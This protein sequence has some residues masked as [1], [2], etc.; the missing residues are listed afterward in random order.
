[1]LSLA[2]HQTIQHVIDN[3]LISTLEYRNESDPD[4]IPYVHERKMELVEVNEVLVGF[5]YIVS[6]NICVLMMLVSSSYFRYL[7]EK[8]LLKYMTCSLMLYAFVPQDSTVWES[9]L[10][11]TIELYVSE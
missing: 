5:I 11:E 6:L 1:M 3:L 8:R 2:K 9:L 4:V 7:W 10:T